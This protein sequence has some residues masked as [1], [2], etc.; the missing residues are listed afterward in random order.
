M[1]NEI[2]LR[3]QRKVDANVAIDTTALAKEAKQDTQITQLTTLLSNTTG[4]SLEATQLLVKGVLDAIKAKTDNLDVTLS[5]RLNT[6]GQKTSA[7]S[8]PVVLASDQ[9]SIPVTT[10]STTTPPQTNQLGYYT[11]NDKVFSFA[12]SLNMVSAGTDNPLF[13]LK[14]PTLNTKKIFIYKILCGATVT[15]VQSTF[16]AYSNPTITNNGTVVTPINN[17]VG[18]LTVSTI[19]TYTLPTISS[20]GSLLRT[21]NNGQNNN[22]V[23]LSE[24]TAILIPPNNNLL[25]TGD[26]SSNNRQTAFT[27]I[28]LEL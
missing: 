14:N 25:I 19:N 7:N 6:L 23:I 2:D 8:T 17:K 10:V 9:T 5:S 3:K 15:N 1:T 27:I 18:S 22:S 12:S 13:L 21:I 20:N 24:E 28:W 4:L 26:P 16:K 11:D